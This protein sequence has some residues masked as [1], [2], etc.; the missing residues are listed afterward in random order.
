MKKN[1]LLLSAL[2]VSAFAQEE[3]P[4]TLHSYSPKAFY[5]HHSETNYNYD[6]YGFGGQYE[7]QREKGFNVRIFFGSNMKSAALYTETETKISYIKPLPEG[8]KLA[9]FFSTR[10]TNHLVDKIDDGN[11]FIMKSVCNLGLGIKLPFTENVELEPEI[12]I[13]QDVVNLATYV[14]SKEIIGMSYDNPAGMRGKLSAQFSYDPFKSIKAE[15]YY[16]TSFDNIYKEIGAELTAIWR[17]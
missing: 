9:P 17:F 8:T 12:S 6:L 16:L 13:F 15:G 5:R 1:L 14:K 3:T 4:K 7:L 2:S 11:H 10:N